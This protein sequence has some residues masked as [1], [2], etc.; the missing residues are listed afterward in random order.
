MYFITMKN[1]EYFSVSHVRTLVQETKGHLL[2]LKVIFTVLC[3]CYSLKE[4]N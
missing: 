3:H 4:V 1:V 2:C